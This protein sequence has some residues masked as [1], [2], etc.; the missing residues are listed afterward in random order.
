MQ[1]LIHLQAVEDEDEE[2][3]P[4]RRQRLAEDDTEEEE[5]EDAGEYEAQRD[6]AES[7]EAQLV[8]KLV[9]Y[10]MACDFSRTPIRRDGIKEKGMPYSI[11]AY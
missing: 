9:R 6:A 7:S 10:A 4:R 3:R 5:G 8:K 2:Q 1:Y 11:K